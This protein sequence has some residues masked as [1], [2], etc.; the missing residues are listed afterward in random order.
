ARRPRAVSRYSVLGT[1]SANDLT[2]VMYSASSSLRAWTLRLPSLA[3][4]SALSSLNVRLSRTASAL[5]IASRTRSWISRSSS[6]GAGCGF[7]FT[8]RSASARVSRAVL[9]LATVPPCDHKTKHDVEAAK[10]SGHEPGPPAERREQRRGPEHH[11]AG[12]HERDHAD[13][14]RAGRR[15][16]GAVEQQPRSRH[17][18]EQLR[19]VQRDRQQRADQK[20]REE[21]EAEAPRR[22]REQRVVCGACLLDQRRSADHH[23]EDRFAEPH[24][25]PISGARLA[26]PQP[27]GGQGGASDD[28]HSPTRHRRERACAFHGGADELQVVERAVAQGLR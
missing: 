5:T 23:G 14:E 20:R 9:L 21:A 25:E 13:R 16:R 4:S 2:H 17:Q 27:G 24:R 11:E 1:R 6:A 10:S 15:Y 19:P 7:V 28:D 3:L 8:A 18:R 22:S 26:Q 12:A